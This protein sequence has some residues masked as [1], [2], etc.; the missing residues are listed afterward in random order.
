M[1][2]CLSITFL[3]FVHSSV[4]AQVANNNIEQRLKLKLDSTPLIS[5]TKNASVQ[6]ECINKKLTNTCLVYHNDQWF[7]FKPPQFGTYYINVI[8]QECRNLKGVQALIIE[9][10]PCETD[11]YRLKHCT[12][13]TDQN[14]TF[15]KLDSLIANKEYLV[16]IDGFLGD[17]CDFEIQFATKPLGLPE[18]NVNLDTL[19]L[20][21]T[22]VKKG[23][24]LHWSANQE[25]LSQLSEFQIYRM[26]KTS[27]KAMILG[28]IEVKS[29]ALGVH[30]KKYSYADTLTTEG[31]YTY[32]IIG[33]NK[34]SSERYLLDETR[35]EF[36]FPK[37]EF[38]KMKYV[39]VMP[40]D[41][42]FK[43]E[44]EILVYDD[45]SGK[46][47]TGIVVQDG[48]NTKTQIDLSRNVSL[49]YRHFRIEAKH[50]NSKNAMTKYFRLTEMGT[51]T[52]GE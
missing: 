29:N 52:Q 42:P 20:K 47:L 51:L 24:I 15:I 22:T 36:R 6:W 45:P 3:I 23:V 12:S 50:L 13:F 30:A 34:F 11:T 17:Q 46:F 37:P 2:R 48:R 28:P 39:A 16:N 21:A 8:N 44:V 5:S 41:F 4:V 31:T 9:G 1:I 10:N 43:G 38:Q 14:D 25:L 35:T 40:L 18:A 7:Y 19:D 49:G 32:Q 33:I 27:K 26:Q